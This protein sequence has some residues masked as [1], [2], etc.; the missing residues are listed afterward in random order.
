MYV[1][2]W[3]KRAHRRIELTG[4]AKTGRATLS[5][6]FSA[7]LAGSDVFMVQCQVCN[8]LIDIR[9]TGK[10]HLFEHQGVGKRFCR[11]GTYK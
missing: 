1:A 3:G 2:P 8:E 9:K 10:R 4:Y 5:D 6:R 7:Y 11:G